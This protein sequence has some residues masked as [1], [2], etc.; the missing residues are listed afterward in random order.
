MAR[1][2]Q[3]RRLIERTFFPGTF[4]RRKYEAFKTL[5]ECN[6]VCHD[7]MARLE[8]LYYSQKPADFFAVGG[9]YESLSE[10]LEGV[11]EQL[12]VMNPGAYA[13]LPVIL[14]KM[15]QAIRHS[16]LTGEAPDTSPP[17]VLSLNDPLSVDGNRVGSKAANLARIGQNLSMNLPGGFAITTSAFHH[18]IMHNELLPQMGEVLSRLDISSPPSLQQAASQL[19]SLILNAAI[20]NP[21]AQ[22]MEEALKKILSESP[23]EMRFAVRSSCVGEDTDLSFAGQYKSLLHVS[24]AHLADAY[25]Q[26]LAS[27]YSPQALVYRISHGLLET[28]TPMA[29]LVL[30]MVDARMSGVL[31]TEDPLCREPDTMVLYW[32]AGEGE[33]LVSGGKAPHRLIF[34]KERG[35][36]VLKG[37]EGPGLSARAKEEGSTAAQ[38]DHFPAAEKMEQ[39]MDLSTARQVASWGMELEAFFQGPQDL[40]WC[41]D[42]Q[43]SV[44]LIQSRPLGVVPRVKTWEESAAVPQEG[45]QTFPAPF[46]GLSEDQ[47]AELHH[48]VLL[49]GGEAASP[50]T[51]AGRVFKVTGYPDTSQMPEGS[52]LVVETSSPALARLMPQVKAVVAQVGSVAGHLAS[53]AREKGIPMLVNVER[54]LQKLAT[55]SEVTVNADEGIILEGIVRQKEEATPRQLFFTHSPF[56]SRLKTLLSKVS[57]L[58]LTDPASS[59]FTPE[60]CRT[61]HDVLRFTHEKAVEEMFVLAGEGAGRVRGAKKLV[62]QIPISLYVLDLNGGIDPDASD[63]KT[64]ALHQVRCEP[65]KSLWAGLTHPSVE[66]S[67]ELQHGDWEEMDR[68]SG[69]IFS[70]DTQ[71]LSS[72]A[73]ISKDYLNANIRFGYH[74]VLLDCLCGDESRE[75]H[76]SLQFEGGG[77]GYEGR[78]LRIQFM[79]RI[80]VHH[81]FEVKSHGDLL[82]ASLKHLPSEMLLDKMA[83]IG[84]LLGVT[85]LLDIRLRDQ[86]QVAELAATFLG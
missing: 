25:L 32:V 26:V 21:V 64:I 2:G 27:K 48:K 45:E 70:K 15:D 38:R 31:Y 5:L 20:P 24:P 13:S 49:S 61:L 79:E 71:I 43:G 63:T 37:V 9:H 53:V 52:V 47:P 17:H 34:S 54:A 23:R 10:A 74:F 33:P 86:E 65:A 28:E 12:V 36:A 6:R 78:R 60:N 11:V 55:N 67:S 30:E 4:I 16:V 66:W 73:I 77:G 85:R 72:F 80:L 29:V 81:G 35:E 62:S 8:E 3:L 59:A 14:R 22:S 46:S 76:L 57:S 68:I 1:L 41:A 19:Q 42:A 51:A 84:R 40:E 58:N 18:L 83:M 75:N 39:G 7:R 82:H 44:F 56:R 69:G 50:G